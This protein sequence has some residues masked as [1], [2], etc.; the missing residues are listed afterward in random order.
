[1]SLVLN[2]TTNWMRAIDDACYVEAAFLDL[3]KAFGTVNHKI[4]H[5]EQVGWSW[6][7][8]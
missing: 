1:M 2:I 7:E 8:G 3:R 5:A 6:Y 4:L